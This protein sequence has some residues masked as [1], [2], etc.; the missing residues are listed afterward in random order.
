[1]NDGRRAWSWRQAFSKSDLAPTTKHVLHTLALFMNEMGES[2]YP[3]IDQLIEH[4]SLSKNA[5]MKHLEVARD[6]GWVSISQHGFKGQRWKRKDYVA[7]WP[8]RKLD[9]PSLTERIVNTA[10]SEEEG[11]ACGGLPPLEK[12]VHEVDEGG[13]RGGPNVVHEVDQDKNNPLNNPI[14]IHMRESARESENVKND[15][16]SKVS[17]ETWVRR[18]KKAHASWSTF[19]S[20]SADSAEKAWFDLTEDERLQA[21]SKASAYERHCKQIGRTKMCAFAVYLKEKRWEKLPSKATGSGTAEPAKPFGK[22]WGVYRFADLLQPHYG[23]FPKP[24]AFLAGLLKG[25]G[26][27]AEREK[28]QRRAQYGWPRVNAMQHRAQTSSKGVTVANEMVPLAD[29]F[30]QVK[31]GSELWKAWEKLHEERGWPWFGVDRDLPEWVYM[32]KLVGT[33]VGLINDNK[34]EALLGAV[35]RALENFEAVHGQIINTTTATQEAA[36]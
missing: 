10:E 6:A 1:M 4:S 26:E 29:E 33:D 16:K 12:V 27:A 19:A 8:E 2:C 9:A 14:P 3:S 15:N 31:V 28:R 34:P 32:P 24:S 5:I 20:D 7:R 11:G 23:N 13:A 36:E 22:L 17:H 30:S 21:S 35:K 18:L 25:D